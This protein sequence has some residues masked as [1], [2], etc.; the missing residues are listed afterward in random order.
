MPKLNTSRPRT[1]R[2]YPPE[3]LR[4]RH[5]VLRKTN[6]TVERQDVKPSPLVE[7]FTNFRMDRDPGAV[8]RAMRKRD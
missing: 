1:R 4:A 5:D 2:V 8:R 3:P 7:N 6:I